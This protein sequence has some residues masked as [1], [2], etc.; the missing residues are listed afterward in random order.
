[1]SNPI[2]QQIACIGFT[3]ETAKSVQET[4][5]DSFSFHFFE[6]SAAFYNATKNT[7]NKFKAIISESDLAGPLG[8][9]LKQSLNQSGFSD[10][11][12]SIILNELQTISAKKVI[13]Q[14]VVEVFAK[15][16][17]TENLG[18]KL[19][20]IIENRKSK[21]GYYNYKYQM[22]MG[23]R[24][25][26]VVFS[27]LALIVLSPVFL[28]ASLLLAFESRGPIFYYSL[29]V[30]T[31]YRIFKFYKF[32][33][34]Y[35]G[36]DSKLGQLQH[37]NQYA[38][39]S[40]QIT[41]NVAELCPTCKKAGYTC[42]AAIFADNKRW[43]EDLYKKLQA[44]NNGQAFIKIKNDP[45]VTGIGRWMR[46]TSIDE[47]PQLWNVLK[48][49][50]SL[51]GNRPLPLYEAEKLTTDKYALR[52][53]AP[54]GITGLWQVSKRGKGEMS[55]DER[56]GLDNDYAKCFGLLYDLKLIMKTI[57]ALFQKENV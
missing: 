41:D 40:K 45:R 28:V 12:F 3:Q 51:V 16:F 6:S 54:A 32:R 46:N 18:K 53:M 37:L 14:G 2:D 13:E 57:P 43:C 22:P 24:I 47:L 27:S 33:S 15:P 4:L 34:M 36:A 42:Q 21:K 39:P 11:P 26:D 29:R 10:I 9:A 25:F 1:M 17:S 50:M 44:E 49:D 48:G 52:F 38:K 8:L 55:E 7:K 35:V 19:Q 30:G 5:T 31:G 56:I 23:K 20:F